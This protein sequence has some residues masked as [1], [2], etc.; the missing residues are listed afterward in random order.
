MANVSIKNLQS[1]KILHEAAVT[2][3]AGVRGVK[4]EWNFPFLQWIV[5]TPNEELKNTLELVN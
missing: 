3:D 1:I 4:K 5:V 2:C